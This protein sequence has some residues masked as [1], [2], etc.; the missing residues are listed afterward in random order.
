[1]NDRA[2]VCDSILK[3]ILLLIFEVIQSDLALHLYV[4][5]DFVIFPQPLK[6]NKFAINKSR[7]DS[8]DSYLSCSAYSDID[9]VY[10]RDIYEDLRNE[11]KISLSHIP[12]D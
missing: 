10:D 3:D 2:Q 9:L 11:G 4:H 7:Y 5:Y 1:M 12:S 6:E 8:I